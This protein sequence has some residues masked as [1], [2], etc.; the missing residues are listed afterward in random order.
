MSCA[1]LEI[2]SSQQ[3]LL[4]EMAEGKA[5]VSDIEITP[6]IDHPPFR[7][8]IADLVEMQKHNDCL[9]L[10]AIDAGLELDVPYFHIGR[11]K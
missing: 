2:A 6:I 5:T 1:G 11:I 10:V 3:S 9:K 4:D 8:L 7:V